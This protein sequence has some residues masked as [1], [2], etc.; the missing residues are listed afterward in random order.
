[1][2]IETKRNIGE[3]LYKVQGGKI[4]FFDIEKIETMTFDSG[5]TLVKYILRV[6]LSAGFRTEVYEDG[7]SNY[8]N[9]PEEAANAVLVAFVSPTNN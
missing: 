5:N 9:T 6:N 2:V 8:H 1:M 3:R 4:D 7:L